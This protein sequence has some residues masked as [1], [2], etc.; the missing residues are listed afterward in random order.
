MLGPFSQMPMPPEGRMRDCLVA[1]GLLSQLPLPEQLTPCPSKYTYF[2]LAARAR[3]LPSQL[4]G[5]SLVG[6]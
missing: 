4:G 3:S 5:R 1:S 2:S 6:S